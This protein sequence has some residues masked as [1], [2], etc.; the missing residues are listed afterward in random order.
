MKKTIFMLFAIG[1][2]ANAQMINSV[3]MSVNGLAIT[4]AEI[5]AVQKQ[6]RVDRAKAIDMLVMDRVQQSALKDVTVLDSEINERISLIASQNNLSIKK[7]KD[8]LATQGT[9]WHKYKERIKTTI[10][11]DKFFREHIVQDMMPPS[12]TQLKRY[13]QKK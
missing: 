3:A 4:T 1:V 2:F 6:F 9:K 13:Y 11:K 5:K 8:I 7:M 12:E 10:K